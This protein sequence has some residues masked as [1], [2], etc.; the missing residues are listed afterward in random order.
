MTKRKAFNRMHRKVQRPLPAVCLYLTALCFTRCSKILSLSEAVW[1]GRWLKPA[2]A[3]NHRGGAEQWLG[4]VGDGE[5][6]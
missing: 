1:A 3:S 6:G 5:A 2:F 4:G